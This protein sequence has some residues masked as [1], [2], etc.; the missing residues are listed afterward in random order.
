M[1]VRKTKKKMRESQ[2]DKPKKSIME[3]ILML[4]TLIF[5][6][7]KEFTLM[8]TPIESIKTLRQVHTLNTLI[9]ARD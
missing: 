1:I 2:L 6:T 3:L 7:S 5:K 4:M 9:Y 8:M